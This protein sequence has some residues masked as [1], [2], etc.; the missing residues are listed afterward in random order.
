LMQKMGDET[1]KDHDS[2]P[3]VNGLHS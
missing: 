2:D 1:G 3:I